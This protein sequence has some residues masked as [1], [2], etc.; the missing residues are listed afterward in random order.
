MMMFGGGMPAQGSM[1]ELPESFNPSGA[2]GPSTM[3]FLS[4]PPPTPAAAPSGASGFGTAGTPLDRRGQATQ[5]QESSFRF[6]TRLEAPAHRSNPPY[7][8]ATASSSV[9][10]Q[11][12]TK[13]AVS[14]RARDSR[15]P[16]AKTSSV[17]D[18]LY[19]TQTVASKSWAPA[20]SV[21]RQGGKGVAV[22]QRSSPTSS[23]TTTM[24]EDPAQIFSRLHITGTVANASKRLSPS[25]TSK[26]AK[27]SSQYRNIRSPFTTKVGTPGPHGSGAS[28]SFP[29]SPRT[30]TRTRVGTLVYSPRM[31][32]KTKLLFFSRH[33]PGLGVQDVP[34]I[35]LGYSFFQSFCAYEVGEIGAKDVAKEVISAF[36]RK[37]FPQER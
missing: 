21:V 35:S 10:Q 30:P 25:H 7:S 17:F 22:E 32:P 20:R 18:R 15:L 26:H 23:S 33:H 1:A 14:N 11:H 29:F 9:T 31:K 4:S 28:T 24:T 13:K 34:P 16:S 27:P 3:S 8:A 5:E 37:D 2:S 6:Q 36:F 12:A 19:K